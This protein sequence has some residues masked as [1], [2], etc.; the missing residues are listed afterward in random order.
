MSPAAAEVR[1]YGMFESRIDG[2]TG[3]GYDVL[4]VPVADGFRCTH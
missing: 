1:E 2:V 4:A 3:P